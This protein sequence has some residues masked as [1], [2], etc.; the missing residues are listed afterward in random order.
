M[1]PVLRRKPKAK[2]FVKILVLIEAF[3]TFQADFVLVLEMI[4]GLISGAS[5]LSFLIFSSFF[6]LGV[7]DKPSCNG[8]CLHACIF[9]RILPPSGEQRKKN[10]E[11]F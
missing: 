6:L 10:K 11:E 7:L 3:G 8:P 5:D 4:N 1:Q 2:Q 9:L